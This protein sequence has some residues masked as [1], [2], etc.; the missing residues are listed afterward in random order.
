MYEIQCNETHSPSV[1]PIAHGEEKMGVENSALYQKKH[2]D[3]PPT[4][5]QKRNNNNARR[6]S[7]ALSCACLNK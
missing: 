4:T 1:G 5:A 2:A 7:V 3:F 6:K